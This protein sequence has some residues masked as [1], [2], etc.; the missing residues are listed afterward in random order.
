MRITI[1]PVDKIVIIDGQPRIN[2]DFDIDPK[3][4]AL[5]WYETWGEVEYKQTPGQDYVHNKIVNSLDGFESALSAW[6]NWIDPDA[7]TV[8][9]IPTAPA[10]RN[11]AVVSMRQARLVLLKHNMLD[12]VEL[13]I[14]STD[15]SIQIEWEYATIVEKNNP[16]VTS[17]AALLQ[18]SQ[19]DV[20]LLFIEANSL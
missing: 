8:P 9:T 1:V 20:D 2:I 19:E 18:L 13:Y 11:I 17:I 6:E 10:D 12:S 15:K 7:P 5:Q 3:I 14:K 4:H 16:L